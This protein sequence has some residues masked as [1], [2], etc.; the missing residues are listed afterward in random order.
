VARR[1]RPEA[2]ADDGTRV[3]AAL[4]DRLSERAARY[5]ARVEAD[6]DGRRPGAHFASPWPDLLARA[7]R[8]EP[9]TVRGSLLR[10]VV[11][12]LDPGARYVVDVD[13]A[14]SL[15]TEQTF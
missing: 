9:V 2:G 6:V 14:V 7:E 12:G 10:D 13:G 3:R 8:G 1:P 15:A 4:L 5:P 11:P